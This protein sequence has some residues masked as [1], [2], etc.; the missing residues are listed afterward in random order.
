MNGNLKTFVRDT[1]ALRPREFIAEAMAEHG[2]TREQ[3]KHHLNRLKADE[4]WVNDEYQVNVDK[5]PIHGFKDMTIWHLSIKRRDKSV[6]HDWR[7]LQ[8]I[9]NMLVGTEA[10]AVELYPAESRLVD[11]ANQFHLW[12]FMAEKGQG[13]FPTLPLGWFSRL[14]TDTPGGKAVQRSR[15]AA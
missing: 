9:K 14:V 10:E 11:T 5:N 6:V 1:L 13:G 12:C 8:Q 2:M 4:I 7:D 15:E 3:A